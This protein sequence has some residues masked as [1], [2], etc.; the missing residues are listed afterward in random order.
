MAWTHHTTPQVQ[1]VESGVLVIL[2]FYIGT[3]IKIGFVTKDNSI[4][5]CIQLLVTR[6]SGNTD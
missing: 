1:L 5:G 6:C 4:V 3:Y 2:E